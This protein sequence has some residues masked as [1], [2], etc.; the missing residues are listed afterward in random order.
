[1]TSCERA[2]P[3]RQVNAA[4][5]FPEGTRGVGLGRD[6]SQTKQGRDGKDHMLLTGRS[7]NS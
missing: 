2:R 6:V 3:H 1:M 5:P 4:Q 7:Q